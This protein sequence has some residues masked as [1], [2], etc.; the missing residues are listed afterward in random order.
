MLSASGDTTKNGR[1][2]LLVGTVHRMVLGCHP[3][4][5]LMVPVLEMSVE[6]VISTRPCCISLVGMA[7]HR[8]SK[9]TESEANA[10]GKS[11]SRALVVLYCMLSGLWGYYL[12]PTGGDGRAQG[13]GRKRTALVRVP[14]GYWRRPSARLDLDVGFSLISLVPTRGAISGLMKRACQ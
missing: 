8:A 9:A 4:M 12:K 13:T 14:L 3:P 6:F 1:L 2:G 10:R 7:L 11:L 5:G